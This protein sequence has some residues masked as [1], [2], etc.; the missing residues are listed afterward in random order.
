[1]SAPFL[2]GMEPT[3]DAT[4]SAAGSPVLTSPASGAAPESLA[5]MDLVYGRKCTESFLRFDPPLVLVENV[6]EM[7]F[8][9]MDRVLGDLAASGHHVAWQCLPA[10]AVGAGHTRD[11]VFVLG[12][13]RDAFGRYGGALKAF[14]AGDPL[15]S[16]RTSQ[17]GWR[18]AESRMGRVAHG[19]PDRVDRLRCLGN[20]VVPQV[21]EF[22]GRQI[23]RA[24]LGC[25]P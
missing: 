21:A 2:P 7:L 23:L 1:M 18:A 24:V 16:G 20:A 17:A 5:M 10:A 9:G 14:S 3:G 19:V 4:S 11:R 13:D 22:I 25:D 15:E 6:A 12:V 8:R